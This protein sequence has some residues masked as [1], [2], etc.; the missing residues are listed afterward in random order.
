MT[1]TKKERTLAVLG[2][3]SM[4]GT[5]G[6]AQATNQNLRSNASLAVSGR[7]LDGDACYS[8]GD[9]MDKCCIHQQCQEAFY[10]DEACCQDSGGC[11]P[12]GDN[13]PGWY[14]T[15]G[16][17]L[18]GQPLDSCYI[19]TGSCQDGIEYIG[20]QWVCKSGGST[21]TCEGWAEVEAESCWT[22]GN[23]LW[24]PNFAAPGREASSYLGAGDRGWDAC[25]YGDGCN[26]LDAWYDADADMG[27]GNKGTWKDGNGNIWSGGYVYDH[28]ECTVGD[29]N[30]D[31]GEQQ[32]CVS[33]GGSWEDENNMKQM[34]ASEGRPI[35]YEG[36]INSPS[37]DSGNCIDGH[38][39]DSNMNWCW[40]TA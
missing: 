33:G 31:S 36:F 26:I 17:D 13:T 27:W 32:C 38:V 20:G 37:D 22:L 25:C 12:N 40:P 19:E 10:C 9:G 34:A 8:P 39:Y 16:G 1:F 6:L 18:D 5:A 29:Y 11:F 14:C 2:L 3:M 30:C 23:D 28:C 15:D 4:L 21:Q 24:C 7:R 35:C